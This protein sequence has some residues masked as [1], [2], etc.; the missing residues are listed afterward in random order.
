MATSQPIG[1]YFKLQQPGESFMPEQRMRV[2]IKEELVW[3]FAISMSN[4]ATHGTIHGIV[5]GTISLLEKD[6]KRQHYKQ[7]PC[8]KLP[9]VVRYLQPIRLFST[10]RE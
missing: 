5:D 10:T 4:N 6:G 1:I 2:T 9:L 8:I 7:Y 3:M